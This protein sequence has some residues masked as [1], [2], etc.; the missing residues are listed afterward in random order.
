MAAAPLV[1]TEAGSGDL[2]SPN[3]F[4]DPF[5]LTVLTLGSGANTISGTFGTGD[6][7]SFAI[8]LPAGL[9]LV[10][11][12]VQLTDGLGDVANTD[13]S[14]RTGSTY[15]TGTTALPTLAA[16]SP[17]TASLTGLPLGAGTYSFSQGAI[18][19]LSTGGPV[20][21]NYTFTLNVTGTETSGV[22]EPS[23]FGLAAVALA[24]L[25]AA[26]PRLRG[27]SSSR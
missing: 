12:D 27:L 9:T 23:T 10:S 25:F 26:R 16:S 7:D 13:W 3:S 11:G 6:F 4:S 2:Y 15:I 19:S 20:S 17:G 24:G 21:A 18:V 14:I 5:G 22:P 1:Y 8:F